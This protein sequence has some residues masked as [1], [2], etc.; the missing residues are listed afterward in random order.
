[1]TEINFDADVGSL[2]KTAGLLDS[3]K[4]T[5]MLS[6]SAVRDSGEP[7]AWGACHLGSQL[8]EPDGL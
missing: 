3:M 4:Y 1:M 8:T 7:V 2:K 5:A 6:A